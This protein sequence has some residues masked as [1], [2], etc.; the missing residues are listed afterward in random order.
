[1][2]DEAKETAKLLKNPKH[3]LFNLAMVSIPALI[4]AGIAGLVAVKV[5]GN[6]TAAGYAVTVKAV[7]TLQ[8]QVFNNNRE[9][10]ELK[11]ANDM[12]QR[13]VQRLERQQE[14]KVSLPPV[15][16]DA[17][18]LPAPSSAPEC[19]SDADCRPGMGCH[20]GD[21]QELPAAAPMMAA[22]NPPPTFAPP[23]AKP[24]NMMPLMPINLDK[25][26]QAYAAE[27]K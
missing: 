12:L 2:A 5:A 21:C 8:Q 10:G 24:M 23:K 7:E 22:V 25:A 4:T 6:E 11:V 19:S 14:F 26:I 9:I 27:K 13:E 17:G 20:H 1:M 18:V 16:A 15:K 3:W